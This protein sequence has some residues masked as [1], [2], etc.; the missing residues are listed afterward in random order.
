METYMNYM[1]FYKVWI[2]LSY[3]LMLIA[4]DMAY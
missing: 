4:E 3:M 1:K 2:E